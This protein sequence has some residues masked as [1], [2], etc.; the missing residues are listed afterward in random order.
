MRFNLGLNLGLKKESKR[1][2]IVDDV[3]YNLEFEE[4]VIK[5]LMAELKIVIDVD[6]AYTVQGAIDMI[7]KDVHYDAMVIDMNL[8][9]GSGLE[10]AKAARAKNSNTRL[11]ALTIYPSKY[12]EEE[13][14]FDIFLKKPIMPSDYKYNFKYLLGM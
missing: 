1:V 10:I 3:A 7:E 9:D 8:P 12:I 4:A 14:Y 5:S 6:V 13:M 2:L 11:A